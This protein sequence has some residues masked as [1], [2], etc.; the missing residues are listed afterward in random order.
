MDPIFGDVP[1]QQRSPDLDGNDP[2]VWQDKTQPTNDLD[3]EVTSEG[4][5][6]H[7]RGQNPYESTSLRDEDLEK[8]Q[9]HKSADEDELQDSTTASVVDWQDSP[10][11][12]HNWP[13]SKRIW[14]ITVTGLMGLLVTFGSSVY[15]PGNAEVAV[16]FHVSDTAAV[17]GL[18][19]YT[20]GLGFGPVLAAPISE[21]LGR[22]VVYRTSI[23][24]FMLFTLGA[25]FSQT[26]AALCAC[27]FLAGMTGGPVLAVGGGTIADLLPVHYRG[28]G[29]AT[30]LLAPFLGPALGPFIGGFAVQYKNWRWTQWVTLFAAVPILLCCF[31]TPETYQKI[32]AKRLAKRQRTPIPTTG[33]TGKAA[34]KFLLTVTLIRPL[35]MLFTEPIVTSFS[36]YTAFIFA[37]LFGF[38]DA[39][40]IVFGGVYGFD[41]SQVGLVFLAIGLGCIVALVVIIFIDRKI[42][43]KLYLQIKAEGGTKVAPEHR[44]YAAIL[45]SLLIP[46]GLFWFAWTARKE[47]HWISPVLSAIPFA[48]GNLLVFIR[49]VTWPWAEVKYS[50]AAD[51]HIDRQACTMCS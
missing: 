33:P 20:L 14:Q 8:P 51:Q 43:F 13:W 11:N 10:D 34:V 47:V 15:T 32:I 50:E 48:C 1:V 5:G 40:P 41:L 29:G 28:I 27:R 46:T 44:L 30:F 26:F 37:V 21:T 42:Y 7:F 12:P 6:A 19:L 25:G 36:A 9:S 31:T 4:P 35:V 2:D 39:F 24:V 16:R 22:S 3:G 45:G 23:F 18:S 38:F 17:L 49:L